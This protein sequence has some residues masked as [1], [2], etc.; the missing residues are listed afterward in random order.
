MGDSG[1]RCFKQDFLVPDQRLMKG[2]NGLLELAQALMRRCGYILRNLSG[3]EQAT[4]H[5]AMLVTEI[6]IEQGFVE[7]TDHRSKP[8][9]GR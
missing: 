7:R 1:N 9:R 6:G 8:T 3:I 5:L 2:L 4:Q